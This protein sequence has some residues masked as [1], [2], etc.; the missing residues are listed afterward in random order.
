MQKPQAFLPPTWLS[1]QHRVILGA[2][3]QD[4][5]AAPDLVIAP[6]H[7]VKLSVTCCCCQVPGILGECLVLALGILVNNLVAA[8][9]LHSMP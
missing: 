2:P 7:G 4:L 8:T 3:A 6:N 9:D 1:N 5:N